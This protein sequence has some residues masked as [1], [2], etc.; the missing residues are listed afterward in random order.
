MDLT[1]LLLLKQQEVWDAKSEAAEKAR[2][3]E[4]LQARR[5]AEVDRDGSVSHISSSASDSAPLSPQQWPLGCGV[6]LRGRSK[7]EEAKA[8]VDPYPEVLS[9]GSPVTSLPADPVSSTPIA[10]TSTASVRSRLLSPPTVRR[11]VLRGSEQ[12]SG[13]A[14]GSRSD[15]ECRRPAPRS[16]ILSFARWQIF[17]MSCGGC[18]LRFSNRFQ[19]GRRLM[20][21]AMRLAHS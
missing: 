13:A 12:E 17:L 18:S 7:F 9:Q 21:M 11:R 16:S 15:R 3:V 8:S 4:T 5:L 10:A 14:A 2:E 20:P 6:A 1:Q 19:D